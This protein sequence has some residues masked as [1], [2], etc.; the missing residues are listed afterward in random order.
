L[1]KIQQLQSVIDELRIESRKIEFSSEVER[2]KKRVI[3]M[4]EDVEDIKNILLDL[5]RNGKI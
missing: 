5:R 1:D 3:K 2:L 4:E